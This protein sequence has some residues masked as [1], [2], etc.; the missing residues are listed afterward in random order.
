MIII[1]CEELSSQSIS[2]ETCC[3]GVYEYVSGQERV[4]AVK[5]Q[6]YYDNTTNMPIPIHDHIYVKWFQT[7]RNSKWLKQP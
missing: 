6:Y 7:Q 1:Q 4:Q 2:I 5:Q 3:W